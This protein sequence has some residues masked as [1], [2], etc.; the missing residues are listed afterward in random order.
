LLREKRIVE[1]N[2][3]GVSDEKLGHVHRLASL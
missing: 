3:A 1:G 2:L